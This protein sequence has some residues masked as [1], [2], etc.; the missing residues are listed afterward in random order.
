[1]E[2]NL[3]ESDPDLV[4]P[5]EDDFRL[6]HDSAALKLGFKPIPKE[7]IGRYQDKH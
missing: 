3:T 4:A 2:N 6:K 5:E 1:M 7:K